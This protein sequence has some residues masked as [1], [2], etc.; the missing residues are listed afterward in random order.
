MNFLIFFRLFCKT[1]VVGME[2][3]IIDPLALALLRVWLLCSYKETYAR[4]EKKHI[5]GR[6]TVDE[7]KTRA[8]M[9]VSVILVDHFG[10]KTIAAT[11]ALRSDFTCFVFS[12]QT[13]L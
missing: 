10:G 13:L 6:L 7:D 5:R 3:V 2:P 9:R 12:V 4:K 11:A 8:R 1:A